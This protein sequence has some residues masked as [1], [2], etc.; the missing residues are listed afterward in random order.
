[1][2][3]YQH[4]E[5]HYSLVTHTNRF[6][7]AFDLSSETSK[8]LSCCESKSQA[9]S[10]QT[11]EHTIAVQPVPSPNNSKIH[12]RTITTY[13]ILYC[14]LIQ[15][16]MQ[17]DFVLYQYDSVVNLHFRISNCRWV[18]HMESFFRER[19]KMCTS[20]GG[21]LQSAASA[22]SASEVKLRR[23]WGWGSGAPSSR[24]IRVVTGD[25]LRMRC[26]KAAQ[27][28]DAT[29]AAAGREQSRAEVS[30]K[31]AT[32]RHNWIRRQP[33]RGTYILFCTNCKAPRMPFSLVELIENM[34]IL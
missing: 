24:L 12:V 34:L 11:V 32:A 20:T 28:K 29:A 13:C 27:T 15:Y 33:E 5:A 21:E 22:T 23:S 18:L 14:I 30:V 19:T 31:E 16:K 6:S 10:F 4:F 26:A 25:W 2:L 7:W 3:A 9:D 17:Y 1:M 8:R